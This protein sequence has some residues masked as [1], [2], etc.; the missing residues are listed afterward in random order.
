M[1]VLAALAALTAMAFLGATSAMAEPTVL[2]SADESPCAAIHQVTHVHETSVGKAILLA[3]P[4]IECNVLFLGEAEEGEAGQV[5][6]EGNFTYTN[7]GTGC[8]VE[9][10]SASSVIEVEKEGH[11]TASVVGEGEFHVSCIGINCYYNRE[12]L[13]ATAKGPLL[14][15][16][17]NGE[18]SLQEQVIHKTKGT[19]CPATVKLDITTT[20]LSATYIR[21]RLP[22][23][24]T[25]EEELGGANPVS[26]NV[27]QCLTGDSINCATGNLVEEQ[28][29]LPA[30]GGRG[31][32]LQVIRSY[33]S[34]L[35]AIQTE[36]GPF[37]YGWTGSY[38]ASLS[39]NSEAET[40]TVRQ[41]NGATAVFYKR[42]GKYYP[43]E[44]NLATL[45]GSGENWIFT[46]PDQ[47]QLEF[48]KS[49]QLIKE[50][51]RHK[52]A[53]TLTYSAGNLETVESSAGRKLTFKFKEGHVESVKDP[54]GN[55]VKY[56]YESGNLAS[57]TLPKEAKANWT[58]KYESP[59]R[60]TEITDGRGYMTKNEYD[61]S[62]RVKFQEDPLESKRKLEY[63]EAGGIRETT[64]TEPNTSKTIEKFNKIG[65]PTETTFASGTELAQ[66]TEY[67]Y[68]NAFEVKTLTDPNKHKTKYG[69][70]EG[71]RILEVD[72]NENETEWTYNS[73]HDLTSE[74]T[75]KNEK[76]TI[77]LNET[78][79]DPE[80][81]KRP[82]P[83]S[84]T[85]ETKFKWAENG[86]LKEETDPLEHTTKYTYDK[87]G[88]EESETDPEGDKTT[89]GY[90]EDGRVTSE[91]SP[92]GNEVPE[93]AAEFETKITRDAQGRPEIV[94]DPLKGETKRKW[95][96]VGNLEVLTNPNENATTYV[97]DKGNQLIK[98]EKK[99][100]DFSK[101]AYDSMGQVKSKTNG[102]N[103]T[104]NY[105]R[106]LL[107]QV[108]EVIDPLE[109]KTTLEYDAAGNLKKL[110]DP[111]KRTITYTYNPG[112][113][114][115][116]VNYSDAGTA[117]VTSEYGEDDEVLKMTDG[118]GTTK[119][120]FDELD[121]LTEVENGNKEIIKY[122]YNLGNEITE[123]TYPNSKVVKRK[124]DDARRLKSIED[125]RGNET[126][127]SYDR[128]STP[129]ATTFPTESENKDEYV[130]D[131]ADRLES[132]TMK[133]GATTLASISYA[134]DKAG[135][136][137]SVTQTGL[138]GAAEVT[139]KYD[140]RERLKEGA[141]TIFKYDAAN[142]PTELGTTKLEYDEASQ[143]KKA[144]TTK[145]AFDELGER[146]EAKPEAG[147]VTKYGFDQAGNL[148][149]VNR[150][151][152]GAVKKIEDTYTYDGNGL[153]AS[154]TVSGKTAHMAWD[155][156]QTQ[157]SML[158]DGTNY[159]LY[160]PEGLPFEQIA[161]ETVT[162][163]HHDQQGSTRLLTNSS[164]EAKGKYTYTPYGGVE[165]YE[166]AAS[167]P[168]GYDGQY[169]NE[170]T[171]LLYLRA[172]SYD[173]TTAQFLS[174]DPLVAET[175]EAYGYV[176]DDPVNEED[177]S[178]VYIDQACQQPSDPP[179]PSMPGSPVP[180]VNPIAVTWEQ[181]YDWLDEV[182]PAIPLSIRGSTVITRISHIFRG[183]P[184][185]FMGRIDPVELGVDWLVNSANLI[186]RVTGNNL[187]TINRLFRQGVWYGA[188]VPIGVPLTIIRQLNGGNLFRRPAPRPQQGGP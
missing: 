8:K 115:K 136:L 119:K 113:Q 9:E 145:Y 68:T 2:C 154:E 111:K 106:N 148:T 170:S 60:L 54:R 129:K 161:G 99:N 149:S 182:T 55:E 164:G 17:A 128:D 16:Q 185:P 174:V 66:T 130:N 140:E 123:I 56:T 139:Y 75:P 116:E 5:V 94:T 41:D 4:K 93:K 151:E 95:D 98:V 46:L 71:N 147:P 121:R 45:K 132:T 67:E 13:L 23:A 40:A 77:T 89:W 160:G 187:L 51:D 85:Q 159:Y 74:T 59:H 70:K 57:V 126:K 73:T 168:L 103:R 48:N 32:T 173:P 33:N 69:Y 155:V 80:T 1:L 163:L 50:T 25:E 82:A 43:P 165:T 109:R 79:G 14:A 27:S 152:E 178:G 42:E 84:K 188:G 28:T 83:E 88:D 150:A 76:T 183:V 180:P 175:G 131:K 91:V 44:W 105:E 61:A 26:P 179:P 29:D 64:I 3:A 39:F 157:P 21:W 49:G 114:L 31:P 72:A 97:Y 177:P 101:T 62:N 172:R 127:F 47:E 117:D 166:G 158:Y 15:T 153:R 86:D 96:A 107:E 12:G 10:Q 104:T 156:T 22:S 134:R 144:G 137:K 20:S 90:D 6:I 146:I 38:T 92:R 108:K 110:E 7:C 162:Y 37:G 63:K 100:G 120:T 176:G 122:K 133:K 30:L 141:G 65:E 81:I 184:I 52:N 171:G 11:E 143:L 112:N 135:Q 18:V 142:N 118:T 87:Y 19:F 124:F 169:R 167:T 102:N 24:P 125:W 36:P 53:L 181:I 186:G 34:L 35:A 138:P 58:F 78:T